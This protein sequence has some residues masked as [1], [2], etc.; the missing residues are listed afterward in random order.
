MPLTDDQQQQG[1]EHHQAQHQ[2]LHGALNLGDPRLGA[3]AVRQL[4]TLLARHAL[5]GAWA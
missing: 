4:L 5:L 2:A 3:G 1:A